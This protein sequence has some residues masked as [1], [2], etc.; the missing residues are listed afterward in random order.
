M[1]VSAST[2]TEHVV[3][4]QP[5]KPLQK[6]DSGTARRQNWGGMAPT[7]QTA[8]EARKKNK[9]SQRFI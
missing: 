6:L 7:M 5:T 1:G 9:V 3:V 2:N 8:S 4:R